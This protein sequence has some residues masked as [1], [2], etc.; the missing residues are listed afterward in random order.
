MPVNRNNPVTRRQSLFF[1][2]ISVE[3]PPDYLKQ[4]VMANMTGLKKKTAVEDIDEGLLMQKIAN[5]DRKAFADL[6]YGYTPRIGNFLLRLLKQ[7]E[8]V[9]EAINDVMLTVWQNAGR[10]DPSQAKLSTWLFGIAN[11]KA[12]KLL[13]KERRHQ[14]EEY[15]GPELSDMIENAA[16]DIATTWVQPAPDNPERTVMGWQLG[17]T[18][19]WA[20]EQLSP[21]HRMVLELAFTEHCAYQD[22]AD[23]IGCPVNTVKT[24]MFHARKKLADLLARRGY[25][26]NDLAGDKP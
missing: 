3:Y 1:R 17:D 20:L 21:D 2:H 8:R 11:N 13:E 22:I 12:L 16:D 7:P 15:V 26:I 19:I 4:G 23:I 18:L 6:Y 10:F 9:D 25:S 24:R 14:N 5:Q